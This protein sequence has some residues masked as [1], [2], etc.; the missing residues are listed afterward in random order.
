MKR[1]ILIIAI[2]LFT[3]S[4]F[5]QTLQQNKHEFSLW[6]GGGIS[7]FDYDLTAG[8]HDLGFGGIAGIGY[9]YFLDYNW[10][11]GIGAEFSIVNAKATLSKS[12][13]DTYD[14]PDYGTL[15]RVRTETNGTTY[16]QKQSAYYI[17]IPLQVKYQFDIWKEHKFYAAIGPKIGIP[18]KSEY[19]TKGSLK[20][21]GVELNANL[22]PI[23]R[24]WYG[25]GQPMHGFGT[26]AIT[27]KK[28]FPLNVNFIA[29]IEAGVKWKFNKDWALYSGVFFD[30]GLND[31]R[32][33]DNNQQLYEYGRKNLTNANAPL[34][35]NANNILTS[36]QRQYDLGNNQYNGSK[37]AFTDRVNTLALGLKLQLTFGIKPFDK[38]TK[39]VPVVE[40]KP[41]EGL[42][43]AQME[44]I[45][46]RNTD[47]LIDAQYKEFEDLKELIKKDDPD[48]EG[49]IYGFD[50]NSYTL[51]PIM[52]PELDHK[53][54][55][56]KKYPAANVELAGHTDNSGGDELNDELG[57]N[58]AKAV[59][60]YLINKGI[61][62]NRL[63]VSTKGKTQPVVS[64]ATEQTR[65]FNRRVEFNL[66]SK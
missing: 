2:G 44:D 4:A 39:V 21:T 23:T 45:L 65:R 32:K 31:V 14:V 46:A 55:L 58:R 25:N 66:K 57:L 62:G 24:D 20:T 26:T 16:E 53:V 28:D 1:I 15:F 63:S 43:A 38:K 51:L 42:T 52:L 29:S 47:K 60:T 6:A 41:Y 33:D 5:A 36:Q 13:S 19:E 48:F 8:K 18:V 10:S 61:N 30:Y 17:N 56:L 54:A 34:T 27:G 35:F 64:N 50:V 3:A 40:E 7:S 11:L 12:F 37:Q 9:N 22:D 59:K 49:V